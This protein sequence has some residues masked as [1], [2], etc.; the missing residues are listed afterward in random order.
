MRGLFETVVMYGLAAFIGALVLF[1]IYIIV[2]PV[3]PEK[4]NL[5]NGKSA[6]LKN[7][8]KHP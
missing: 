3:R 4:T 2:F 8:P 6:R 1:T 5:Q 7:S